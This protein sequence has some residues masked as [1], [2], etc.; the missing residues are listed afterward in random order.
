VSDTA[1][2]RLDVRGGTFLG[3]T[4]K[5]YAALLEALAPESA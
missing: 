4:P 3:C 1:G 5:I 2:H